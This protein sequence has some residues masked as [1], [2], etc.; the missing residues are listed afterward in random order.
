MSDS[1]YKIQALNW[2][3]RNRAELHRMES[4]FKKQEESDKKEEE[5]WWKKLLKM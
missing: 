4:E 1:E 3:K 2:K 5:P